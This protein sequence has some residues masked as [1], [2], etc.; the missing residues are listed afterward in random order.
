MKK[1]LIAVTALLAGIVADAALPHVS[2]VS[3]ARRSRG[4]VTIRYTLDIDAVVTFDVKT[5]GVSIGGV[6]LSGA[7]GDVFREVSAGAGRTITWN[8]LEQWPDGLVT[9]R[10]MHVEV[11]AWALS[12]KPDIMV[13][14]LNAP[15]QS[16]VRYYPSVDFLPGGLFGNDAY[17][18]SSIVMKRV[19][20]ANWTWTMGGADGG[21]EAKEA[22]HSVT[23]TNDYY[24]ALFET[25]QSCWTN[26]YGAFSG[27]VAP[28]FAVDG[29]MRPM[30]TAVTYYRL[31]EN[32]DNKTA[33]SD[34][35]YPN[36]PCPDSFLGKLRDRTGVDFDLPSEAQ[37]E[38]AARSGAPHKHYNNWVALKAVTG[39]IDAP[40]R[41]TTTGATASDTGELG[42]DEG[43]TAR[44]GSYAPSRWGFYD[45]HGN[46]AEL[47]LDWY[48]VDILSLNGAVNANGPYLADGVTTGSARS[49]HGSAWNVSGGNNLRISLRNSA[50]PK[51]G[52]NTL[53]FRLCCRNG[54]E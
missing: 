43:G 34:Y 11:L 37:W 35:Q 7:T 15:K 36:P 49:H 27:T 30:E 51:S 25:T 29:D 54:L 21:S 45:F 12:D 17:R 38:F 4:R 8:A 3:F 53:G 6:H 50:S 14:D 22:G 41:C 10:S 44:V 24:M 23:L 31:R 28:T 46:V 40:G 48:A 20:A 47:C 33:N 2:D 9:D 42:P 5:N 19:H 18:T 32:T 1:T 39:G 26:V 16:C 52:Y 13:V